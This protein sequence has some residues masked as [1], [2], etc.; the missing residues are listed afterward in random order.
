[1]YNSTTHTLSL[2]NISIGCIVDDIISPEKAG[3]L[4]INFPFKEAD[5]DLCLTMDLKGHNFIGG[6]SIYSKEYYSPGNPTNASY[7][8]CAFDSHTRGSLKVTGDGDLLIIGEVCIYEYLP[9]LGYVAQPTFINTELPVWW[10]SSPDGRNIQELQSGAVDILEKCRYLQIGG[11]KPNT[12]TTPKSGD[13]VSKNL[14][15]IAGHTVSVCY[16]DSIDYMAAKILKED[17][18]YLVYNNETKDYEFYPANSLSSNSW[19]SVET[20]GHIEGD[21]NRYC[22]GHGGRKDDTKSKVYAMPIIVYIDGK[23]V[24]DIFVTAKFRNNMNVNKD[25]SK[26]P[27]FSFKLKEKGKLS[28]EILKRNKHIDN[29]STNDLTYSKFKEDYK[30]LCLSG[31]D[32]ALI[33]A[34]DVYFKNPSNWISFNINPRD[35]KYT[36]FKTKLGNKEYDNKGVHAYRINHIIHDGYW[37]GPWETYDMAGYLSEKTYADYRKKIKVKNGRV[38]SF[39]LCQGIKTLKFDKKYKEGGS[40]DPK[41]DFHV[42]ISGNYFVV[43]G[44]GNFYN[45]I[46]VPNPYS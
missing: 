12:L 34:V 24:P 27:C 28:K 18:Y 2:D 3:T 31:I 11:E 8:T 23:P 21:I 43:E 30:K 20:E 42:T 29:I 26:S 4:K 6:Y 35:I 7:E 44:Q 46:I 32:K 39:P 45:S 19:I 13:T 38:S 37:N 40:P 33:K 14:G 17:G 41:K 22:L 15:S 36:G 16:L 10:S 5:D 25:G 9:Y 1:M